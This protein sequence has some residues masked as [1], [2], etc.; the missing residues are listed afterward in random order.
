MAQRQTE[1][2]V[3]QAFTTK[4]DA[5]QGI[6]EAIVNVFGILDD[7]GDIVQSGSFVKTLTERA[8]RVK[9]LNAHN[10]WDVR[11]VIG[12][13][14]AMREV[15]RDDL[16]ESVLKEWPEATGGLWT[17]TQYLLDTPEGKGAFDRIKADAVNEYSIGYE[18]M[19]VEY[20]K[21][22]WRGQ[23]VNAR[24]LKEVRLWEYS[25]V[26]WGMNPAT[27]TTGVKGDKEMSAQGAVMR[28]GD[29]L[30]G[31]TRYVVNS[32]A[33]RML[34]YGRFSAE[35]VK[36][37]N[38]ALDAAMAAFVASLPESLA[39]MPMSSGGWN[40][41][42][43]DAPEGSKAS[44]PL[45]PSPLYG[46]GESKAVS[47]DEKAGRVLS[48]RNITK[49]RAAVVSLT[50]VLADAG[51]DS[52]DSGDEEEAGKAGAQAGPEAEM[53]PPTDEARAKLLADIEQHLATMEA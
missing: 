52:D 7:G 27:A 14:L 40:W 24:L 8:R 5:E 53:P 3:F 44:P 38:T 48:T 33:N 18:A 45:A 16:P 17:Q 15:G 2:K 42:S 46:E 23:Q 21:V 35:D 49:I 39:L 22:D 6:V 26:V 47:M 4:I 10:S 28:V 34:I 12:K 43:A 11:S 25:P 1:H 20:R 19:Q 51:D 41:D 9:V 50:E 30:Q 36:A 37:I 13:V 32:A 29:Y 31:Q